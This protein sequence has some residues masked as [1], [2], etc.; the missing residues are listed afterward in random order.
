MRKYLLAA[1]AAAVFATPAMARDDS[2]YV[3]L[4]GGVL[5]PQNQHIDGRCRLHRSG[6]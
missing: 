3:G 4:E 6:R 2:G 1:A 5:F